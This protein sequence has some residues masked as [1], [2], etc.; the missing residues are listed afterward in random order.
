ML[1]KVE[2]K[3]KTK[4]WVK[5]SCTKQQVFQPHIGLM[6]APEKHKIFA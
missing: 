4:L 3:P 2:N 6:N 5:P 1:T